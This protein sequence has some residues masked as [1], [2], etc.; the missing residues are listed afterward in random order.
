MPSPS[1]A[2]G[3]PMQAAPGC[4]SAAPAGRC[5]AAENAG[6]AVPGPVGGGRSCKLSGR[7]PGMPPA[8]RRRAHLP[9][10]ASRGAVAC[11]SEPPAWPGGSRRRAAAGCAGGAR[12]P[13]CGAGT[14][15]PRSAAR[16]RAFPSWRRGTGARS[17]RRESRSGRP[18]C[19]S[20]SRPS[21]PYPSRSAPL[22]RQCCI[23]HS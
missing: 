23:S 22:P 16:R 12:R 21:G 19:P 17:W 13:A 5:G 4:P 7:P 8:R 15:C 11:A 20:R 10:R 9:G 2:S 18:V 6:A 14:R 3:G 1:A